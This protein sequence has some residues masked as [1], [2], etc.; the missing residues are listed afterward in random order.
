MCKLKKSIYRL[1]QSPR[2]WFN[3]FTKTIKQMGYKQAQ[4]DHTLFYKHKDGKITI[5]IVYVDNIILTRHDK[6]AMEDLKEKLEREF[7]IK[8][9]GSM[10]YLLSMEVARN[11]QDISVSQR[12]YTLDHLK[13]TGMMGYKPVDTPMDPNLKLTKFQNSNPVDKGRY[14]R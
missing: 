7:E 12:K 4:T 2:A 5:L 8:D 13:E 3:Q 1:K 10:R 6:H 11:Q 9:F 14:Q